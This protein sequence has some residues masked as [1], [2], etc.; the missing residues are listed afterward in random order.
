MAQVP[1]VRLAGGLE[2][3]RI[4]NGMWQVSGAHG[5]VDQPKAG[6]LWLATTWPGWAGLYYCNRLN[7]FILC[8]NYKWAFY[9][10]RP[11]CSLSSLTIISSLPP[12]SPG[13]AS[14]CWRWPDHLWHGRHLWTSRGY[15][16]PLPQSGIRYSTV[17]N[18]L[19]VHYT[20]QT[21]R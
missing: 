17:N 3:C 12:S 14:L 1:K 8:A 20:I 13:H 6:R 21:H 19:Y 9:S 5:P 2:I 18:I 7:W 16:R 15:I 4:L 11:S 10:F